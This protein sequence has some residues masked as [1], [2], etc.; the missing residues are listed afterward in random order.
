M[1]D[2]VPDLKLCFLPS[3]SSVCDASSQA[4]HDDGFK[5]TG[6]LGSGVGFAFVV[7]AVEN[8]LLPCFA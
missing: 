7:H 4:A 8:F 1:W 2:T 3:L 5:L 6:G